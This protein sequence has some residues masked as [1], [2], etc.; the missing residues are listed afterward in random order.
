MTSTP[1]FLPDGCGGV[2]GAE[3]RGRVCS[4]ARQ[5]AVPREPTQTC[6]AWYHCGGLP[7][8]MDALGQALPDTTLNLRLPWARRLALRLTQSP[9]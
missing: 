6:L 1:K 4:G 7:S 9:L 5:R 3:P 8:V 2:F